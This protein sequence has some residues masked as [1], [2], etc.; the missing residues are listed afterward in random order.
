MC[1]LSAVES[2]SK[3]EG[4]DCVLTVGVCG[5][6]MD[7]DTD[8]ILLSAREACEKE[9]LF[10]YLSGSPAPTRKDV[11][12]SLPQ[13]MRSFS[14]VA[15]SLDASYAY[16]SAS[17]GEDGLDRIPSARYSS[18][19]HSV[20]GDAGSDG[21]EMN[22]ELL[23]TS[24]TGLAQLMQLRAKQ[25]DASECIRLGGVLMALVDQNT[26]N[27]NQGSGDYEGEKLSSEVFD[28]LM[29][30]C[31]SKG[32]GVDRLQDFYLFMVERMDVEPSRKSIALVVR[33]LCC[34]GKEK[35]AMD[36]ARADLLE[37]ETLRKN[38]PAESASAVVLPI[39][40]SLARKRMLDEVTAILGELVALD[41]ASNSLF[42]RITEEFISSKDLERCLLMIELWTRTCSAAGKEASQVCQSVFRL[43]WTGASPSARDRPHV[44]KWALSETFCET[45]LKRKAK[46]EVS[47]G[48]CLLYARKVME[49]RPTE[50]HKY[51]AML[52]AHQTEVELWEVR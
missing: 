45:L 7:R 32:I 31:L 50:A 17:G 6:H 25:G 10:R 42:V 44:E 28:S 20:D 21:E 35:E 1:V 23:E 5:M 18:S 34:E 2:R 29:E 48:A 51:L 49:D 11:M 47:R 52:L 36:I 43:I 13:Q 16:A 33:A 38:T 37:N 8:G 30:V 40:Q 39:L 41:L 12:R 3:M 15:S 14:G 22:S 9:L 24:V 19:A 27:S 26:M 4:V 46:G